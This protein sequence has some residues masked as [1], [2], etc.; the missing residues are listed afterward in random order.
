[1]QKTAGFARGAP[2]LKVNPSTLMVLVDPHQDNL[3]DS[4]C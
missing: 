1:M 3:V 4:N 2:S